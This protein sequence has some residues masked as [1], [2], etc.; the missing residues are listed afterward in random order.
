MLY[1]LKDPFEGTIDFYNNVLLSAFF[2]LVEAERV[3][4]GIRGKLQNQFYFLPFT[5]YSS[6]TNGG[7]RISFVCHLDAHCS[8]Q[9]K[10]DRTHQRPQLSASRQPAQPTPATEICLKGFAV[11]CQFNL[12][13]SLWVLL[14]NFIEQV[15]Y[16]RQLS[17]ILHYSFQLHPVAPS[18]IAPHHRYTN[19]THPFDH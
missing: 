9:P 10:C 3:R 2:F 8:R 14:R 11:K 1:S 4:E 18:S 17:T 12:E 7:V 19:P 15:V 6:N 13:F 5:F 16:N